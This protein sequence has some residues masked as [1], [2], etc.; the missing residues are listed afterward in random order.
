MLASFAEELKM[1]C[2]AAYFLRTNALLLRNPS[3]FNFFDLPALTLPL[4]RNG[5]LAVGLMLVGRRGSDRELLAL[6]AAIEQQ[7]NKHQ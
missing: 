4:P 7:F 5:A 2:P 3:V 6:G 1:T